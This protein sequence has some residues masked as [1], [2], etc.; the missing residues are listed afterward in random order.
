MKADEVLAM[1]RGG[2]IVSCQAANSPLAR[3]D[4]I[5]A[6][7]LV[8]EQNGAVGVRIDGPANIGAVR[9][10][11]SVPVLG[12]EKLTSEDSDVYITPTYD[13]ARRVAKSGAHVVALDATFR[14]RPGGENFGRI[15]ARV[16]E[17]LNR[18]V[19]AD[20]ATVE[21]GVSAAEDAGVEMVSTT[22]AGYTPETLSDRDEPDYQLIERL[23]ARLRV[24]VI[25]EGRVRS[26]EQARRAFDSGAYAVV[27][28]TAITGI[29]WLVRH[30]VEAAKKAATEGRANTLR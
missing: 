5:A 30:Y 16:H 8:A 11:V 7:A 3:P 1:W 18:P 24:P 15:V 28:G 12:I 23:A 14:P 4:I 19:M 22:L 25:C 29:D 17:E 27:V 21:E 20:V 13:S 10:R 9:E 2:L 26:P 6:L